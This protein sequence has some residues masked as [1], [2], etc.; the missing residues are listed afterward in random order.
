MSLV[1]SEYRNNR[2]KTDDF[3]MLQKKHLVLEKEYVK[4]VGKEIYELESSTVFGAS[5]ENSVTD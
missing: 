3:G 2:D 4:Y 1:F 5:E